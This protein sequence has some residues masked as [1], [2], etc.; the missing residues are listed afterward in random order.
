M[1]ALCGSLFLLIVTTTLCLWCAAYTENAVAHLTAA[2]EGEASLLNEAWDGAKFC[3]CL[4]TN[5]SLIAACER[6]LAQMQAFP[7]SDPLYR[8]A[9]SEFLA[10]LAL[11]RDSYGLHLGSIL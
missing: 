4:T 3:L 10:N 1:K 2:A 11:I 7:A 5:R 9:K 6:S 8:S